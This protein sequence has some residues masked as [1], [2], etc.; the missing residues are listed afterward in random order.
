MVDRFVPPGKQVFDFVSFPE[1]Y[2]RRKALTFYTSSRANMVSETLLTAMNVAPMFQGRPLP[3]G[4]SADLAPVCAMEYRFPLTS[5]RAL[6]LVQPA[7]GAGALWVVTDVNLRS[8]GVQIGLPPRARVSAS[9]SN[10]YAWRALDASP[11]TLWS[12][13]EPA[14][15]GMWIRVDF[16]A[17]LPVDGLVV[18]APRDQ[19]SLAPVV[20][21]STGGGEWVALDA[22]PMV[23]LVAPPNGLR[24]LAARQV[25]REGID[26][27]LIN[28]GNPI[29]DDF[30]KNRAEW[31]LEQVASA[32]GFTLYRI[33]P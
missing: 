9:Q 33:R 13:R 26:Y 32:E 11:V 19:R 4:V 27:L 14:R 8:R 20:E 16:P 30:R 3:G 7:D 5:V 22:R 17:P 21:A 1:A 2:S 15:K 10:W 28:E 6:R 23:S 31:G 24:A 25:R 18:T 12:S 29:G